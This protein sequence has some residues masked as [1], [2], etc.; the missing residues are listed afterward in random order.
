MCGNSA[1]DWNTVLTLRWNGGVLPIGW[2]FRQISPEVGY[3]K[4]AI[5]RRLVVL[6]QP[7]GPSIEKNSP[8]RISMLT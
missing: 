4:P 2:P 6:P 3:S 8:S 1:Y 5:I 7:D